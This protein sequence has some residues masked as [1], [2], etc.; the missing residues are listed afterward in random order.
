MTA[1]EAT[2]AAATL[3]SGEPDAAA[4]LDAVE[5]RLERLKKQVVAEIH[6]YPPPIPRCDAQFNHLLEQRD[7]MLEEVRRL[8]ELRASLAARSAAER[9]H[10]VRDFIAS[11]PFP[12]ES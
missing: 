2:A 12:L 9:L 6:E 3:S 4:L 7:Q 5:A 11:C 10:A 1:T 8:T